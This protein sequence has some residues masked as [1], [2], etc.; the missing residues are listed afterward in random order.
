MVLLNIRGEN[1]DMDL[2]IKINNCII[3]QINEITFLC[4]IIDNKLDWKSHINMFCTELNISIAILNKLKYKLNRNSLI[5]LYKYFFLSYL[6][7]CNHIWG[8][9]L[10]LSSNIYTFYNYH[11][12]LNF[13]DIVKL[14]TLMFMHRD[15]LYTLPKNLQSLFSCINKK[16]LEETK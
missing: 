7:Y 3:N 10:H 16:K 11:N 13:Y 8:T 2:D 4:I 5:L 14:N 15:I 6:N 12:T 1:N 9:P